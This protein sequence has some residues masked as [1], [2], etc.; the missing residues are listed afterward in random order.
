MKRSVVSVLGSFLALSLLGVGCGDGEPNNPVGDG[1]GDATDGGASGD[2]EGGEPSVREVLSCTA[3]QTECD[4]A[5]TNT[6]S[7]PDHCG[8]CG[9]ECDNG[10]GCFNGACQRFGCAPGQVE[11]DDQ[12]V[13]L[14][15]DA[16]N[17]GDCG[18]ACDA[19]MV[20]SN[21]ACQ[22][23][24]PDG[25]LACDGGCVDPDTDEQFCG[26]A[27]CDAG[28]GQGGSGAES[29]GTVCAAGERCE[30]GHCEI[31]CTAGRIACGDDCIDPLKDPDFCG[32]TTCQDAASSGTV[33]SQGEVCVDGACAISCPG[34]QLACNGTCIV[35]ETD[36]QYCGATLCTDEANGGPVDEGEN[37]LG[38]DRCEAGQCVASCSVGEVVC[39]DTCID[40]LTDRQYCG[41]QACEDDASDGEIC[42]DGEICVDGACETSCPGALLECDDTCIDPSHDE[43]FCGATACG[44]DATDG[45]ICDVSE[46]CVDGACQLS[47]GPDLIAC[48]DACVDPLGDPAYCG[49]TNCSQTGGRGVECNDQQAC[50]IGECREFVPEWSDGERVDIIDEHSVYVG[51]VVG[52]NLAGKAVA[53]WRQATVNDP[54][55]TVRFN[56]NRA[57]ASVYDPAT[58]RWSD[59]VRISPA[60][61]DIR[62]LSISVTP[63]GDAFATWVE[64]GTGIANQLMMA[65]LD[66]STDTWAA[67][68]RIDDG[69]GENSIDLPIVGIDSLGNG[70]VAW[71]EGSSASSWSTTAILAR[72]FTAAGGLDATIYTMPRVTSAG[73]T[74]FATNP[75]M[76]VS[77]T[78]QVVLSWIETTQDPRNTPV[79]TTTSIAGGS[80]LVWSSGLDLQ[81]GTAYSNLTTTLDAD[82]DDAGNITVVYVSNSVSNRIVHKDHY[83]ASTSSW[84]SS[85]IDLLTDTSGVQRV[86]FV[87][88]DVAGNGDAW[89]AFMGERASE[90]PVSSFIYVQPFH[91]ATQSWGDYDVISAASTRETNPP[92]RPVPDVAID[93][94][95]NVFVSWVRYDASAAYA[96][97]TRYDASVAQWL[98]VT[99]LN[100]TSLVGASSPVLAVSGGGVAFASWVQAVSGLGS[101]LYVGRF[102]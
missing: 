72:R 81:A 56:S 67:P 83:T 65:R 25:Q 23:S 85:T 55:S 22:T 77:A 21:G 19:G 70:I 32:A 35:P 52:A 12:C 16:E 38:G 57:Y 63:S 48:D 47:C 93:L 74:P 29:D 54:D 66:G 13:D 28:A 5:C 87:D 34:G 92:S 8:A 24:C 18:E 97:A 59:Q 73:A 40:P 62:N 79:V 78:G 1:D 4:D 100:A 58:K 44:D 94:Q 6:H 99:Q 36:N 41:A 45:E 64:G 76:G 11:C 17:C 95:G 61:I 102:N 30:A 20:C 7:D 9:Q 46:L 10:Q 27:Q 82:I 51:Q 14:Q 69:V 39:D 15:R 98:G 37:C 89:L 50:V 86:R 42:Q 2:G 75:R 84:S 68:E 96:E 80:N 53:V 71:S 33:C 3:R 43:S 101:H 91:A 31:S 49:A 90:P 26:A 88:L 60:E